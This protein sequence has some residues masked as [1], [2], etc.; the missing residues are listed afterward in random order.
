MM[1][2]MMMNPYLS[3]RRRFPELGN[4]EW[5]QE[6]RMMELSGREKKFP[7]IFRRWIQYMSATDGQPDRQDTGRQ[8][9]PR[10]RM[11]SRGKKQ[12]KRTQASSKNRKYK[13]LQQISI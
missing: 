9:V 12:I 2:M 7:G 10:L 4:T 5:P 13:F 6:T 3:P 1:M 8:L 11:A